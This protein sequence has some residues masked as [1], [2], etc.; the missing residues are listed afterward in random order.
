MTAGHPPAEAFLTDRAEVVRIKMQRSG[1]WR[2][3]LAVAGLVVVV[4][5]GTAASV[6]A[7]PAASASAYDP[8]VFGFGYNG[9]GQIGHGTNVDDQGL[10]H[11]VGLPVDVRQIAAGGST[12]A[13]LLPDGTVWMWGAALNGMSSGIVPVRVPGLTGITQIAMGQNLGDLFAVGPGGGVWAVGHNEDG[14]LGN[15]TTADDFSPAPVPGLTGIT[16]VSAG[17]HDT[18]AVRSDGTVWAW[19]SNLYG[20]LGDGTM[21]NRL[22]PEQVP[23]LSGI[24][25]VSAG[26]YYTVA[27][28]S[29]GT[30]W[31]WGLTGI[32]ELNGSANKKA[33]LTPEQVPGLSGI[34]Q[35]ATDGF[36]TL[37]LRSD[38]TVWAWG[39]NDH[40][41]L[42]DGT[43]ATRFNPVPLALSA[44][45]QIAV[46][47][48]AS[49]AVRS[50]GTLLTWGDN[51]Y[52]GLDIGT[53]C[54]STL[55]PVPTPAAGLTLVTQVAFGDAYGL[56][57][58]TLPAGLVPVPSVIGDTQ[59]QASQDLQAAGLA[60]GTVGSA[61]DPTCDNI[62][63]VMSQ[64]PAAGTYSPRGTHV[65]I[66]IGK[67]NP[68]LCP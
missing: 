40:G 15:G 2:R 48:A 16:Q 51:A 62:G 30:V 21:T 50:D 24:T 64:R 18:V 11:V 9:Y 29:D 33:H 19:G 56:A 60:L 22:T 20:E 10:G 13:A 36:H 4:G 1:G 14:Q 41:E 53:C 32:G 46:G 59:A 55:N 47:S 3:V 42:G 26:Y 38:G 7:A 17:E 27:V 37:A 44:V 31:F 61:L 65:S 12:S 63:T 45:T 43:T 57:L 28:R 35:V 8:G 67:P 66:T 23:G 68:R 52:G 58:S 54:G 25:Q 49:A 6:A 5:A 34:T 39:T